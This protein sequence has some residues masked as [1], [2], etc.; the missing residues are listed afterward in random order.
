LVDTQTV[1]AVVSGESG[2]TSAVVRV[3]GEVLMTGALI[4]TRIRRTVQLWTHAANTQPNQPLLHMLAIYT[5][6]TG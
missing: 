4:E 1:L 2:V 5:L 6:N 3:G